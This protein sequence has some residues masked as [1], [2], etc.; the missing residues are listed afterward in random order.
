MKNEDVRGEAASLSHKTAGFRE[1]G[2]GTQTRWLGFALLSPVYE[3]D[4][5]VVPVSQV[6]STLLFPATALLSAWKLSSP[7]LSAKLFFILQNSDQ[8][9]PSLG[10][11][12][13][14]PLI[15][16]PASSDPAIGH[17]CTF[18]TPSLPPSQMVNFQGLVI[19]INL[20][21][22]QHSAGT[23]WAHLR[24]LLIWKR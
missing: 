14:F 15:Y 6:P 18:K 8:Q 1:G 2:E 12:V 19:F 23:S 4:A 5:P 3:V 22:G 9:L 16:P 10:V 13:G 17:L 11:L 24:Y 7:Y 20:T 21:P